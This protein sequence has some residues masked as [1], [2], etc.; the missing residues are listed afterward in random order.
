M[1]RSA[2]AHRPEPI[3]L[4]SSKQLKSVPASPLLSWRGTSPSLGSLGLVTSRTSC[5]HPNGIPPPLAQ[6]FTSSCIV[7]V[8][9]IQHF[10][11]SVLVHFFFLWAASSLNE[12][13]S[14]VVRVIFRWTLFSAAEPNLHHNSWRSGLEQGWLRRRRLSALLVLWLQS[15]IDFEWSGPVRFPINAIILGAWFFRK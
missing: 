10:Q 13:P 2:V 12:L 5:A 9:I 1:D 7:L 15:C 14:L 4:Y 6:R 8:L 11:S 3:Q